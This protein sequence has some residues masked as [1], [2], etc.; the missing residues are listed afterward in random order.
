MIWIVV[1]ARSLA[2]NNADEER[3]EGQNI[4]EGCRNG[5]GIRL[6]HASRQPL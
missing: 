6:V 4:V 2:C 3:L 1:P 5:R